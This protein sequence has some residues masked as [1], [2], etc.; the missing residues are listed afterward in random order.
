MGHKRPFTSM[1]FGVP[2]YCV[3]I[4]GLNEVE[5]RKYVKNQEQPEEQKQLQLN[6]PDFQ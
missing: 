6:L 2:G 4:L 5:I 1:H 3:N